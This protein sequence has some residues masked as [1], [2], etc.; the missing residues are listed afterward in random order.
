MNFVKRL[1]NFDIFFCFAFVF[2]MLWALSH[3]KINTD[4]ID[5]IG[6][7]L[8]DFQMNDLVYTALREEP[9]PDTNITM[10][11]IG[12][13]DRAGLAQLI[14]SLSK[15]NPKVIGID[16]FY[17]KD[18][19][20]YYRENGQINGDSLLEIAF[21]QTKNLVLVTK[22]IFNEKKGLFDTLQ[23][24]HPKFMRFAKGGFA[25]VV[26]A[27][28]EFRV[29]RSVNTFDFC[30]GKLELFFPLKIA[31]L[32]DS[33]KVNKYLNR[34]KV[35]DIIKIKKQNKTE[36]LNEKSLE[37]IYYRGNINNFYGEKDHFG[38]KNA[39]GVID[40]D[41]VLNETFDPSLVTGKI[42][43]LGYMGETVKNDKYWDEDK[44]YT[45]L[46]KKFAGKSF[47][48]MYGVTVH[49]NV[50]SM[51]LNETYIDE[52]TNQVSLII[53]LLICFLNVI[54][55]S[56]I[57]NYLKVWWDGFSVIITLVEA[58]ILVFI[59]LYFFE[60]S[61]TQINFEL[62]LIFI[63]VLGNFLELYFEYVKPGFVF[64]T[65]KSYK[66]INVKK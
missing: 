16:A 64:L 36:E 22:M 29:S 41:E 50:L 51:I 2:F 10:V 39:F 19:T 59:E 18:K 9:K 6:Q 8:E 30:D 15:H 62:A 40:V 35:Q 21:S 48:D 7:A 23:T 58:L 44:F 4:I 27:E 61:L 28:K 20:E 49:A 12:N 26:T 60:Y 1:I 63:F 37:T 42:L 13:L 53:S 66:F 3:V 55:F 33:S 14:L 17:R 43:V 32:F 65:Q 24:S 54:L 56:Y 52:L 31:Q 46:N 45:P 5:P 57:H 47:P 34:P 25:N 38:K 11:N